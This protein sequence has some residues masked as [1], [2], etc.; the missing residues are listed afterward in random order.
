MKENSGISWL[1]V[2]WKPVKWCFLYHFSRAEFKIMSN[3]SSFLSNDREISDISLTVSDVLSR[4]G[5]GIQ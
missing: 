1:T 4:V 2:Y 5:W 3:M